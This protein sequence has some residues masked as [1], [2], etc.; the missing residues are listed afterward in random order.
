MKGKS[1]MK[2]EDKSLESGS[3]DELFRMEKSVMSKSNFD[4]LSM[5]SGDRIPEALLQYICY[6]HQWNMFG[7]GRLDPVEFSKSFKFSRQFLVS[8]HEEPYQLQL[9][10]IIQKGRKSNRRQVRTPLTEQ[11][12]ILCTNRLE[13]A[14]Y[15]LANYALKV[16]STSVLEDKTLVRQYGFLRVIESFAMVQDGKTGKVVYLYKLDD[17]FRRNLSSLYLTTRRD[18]FVSL[19]KSGLGVLYIFLLKLREALYLQGESSTNVT[20]TPDFEYLCTLASIH[21]YDEAK[22]RKRDLN[23]AIAKIRKMTELEFD[24]EWVKGGGA[25][26]YVPLFHFIPSLDFNNERAVKVRRYGERVSVAVL[27]FKHNLI[28]VCPF[29]G[30][31]YDD[32]AEDFFFEWLKTEDCEQQRA[33]AFALE[34]T[35]VNLGCGIPCDIQSRVS[36]LHHLASSREKTDI[37]SWLREIFCDNIRGFVLPKFKCEERKE[38]PPDKYHKDRV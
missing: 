36:L 20:T 15:I 17:K 3:Q 16:T 8:R 22:Y 10:K 19:R 26:R 7:Y 29:I 23:Q 21:K 32:D 9:R 37:D 4:E 18:S 14:L 27:E 11:N 35:F 28:D 25:E 31:R 33:I 1:I 13:N 12:D 38:N 24:V 34:K 30:N 5:I 2:R 6:E